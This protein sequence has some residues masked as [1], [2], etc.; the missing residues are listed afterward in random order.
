MAVAT[1]CNLKTSRQSFSTLITRTIP[2]LKSINLSLPDLKRIYCSY[3]P[4]RRD[5]DLFPLTLN[6]YSVYRLWHDHI[7]YQILAKSNNPLLSFSDLKFGV[8][9]TQPI[10]RYRCIS[11]IAQ[12]PRSAD[13]QRTHIPRTSHLVHQLPTSCCWC[14]LPVQAAADV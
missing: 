5:L 1:H 2:S 14:C 8:P 10:S 7:L 13:P 6:A 9:C 11:I 12:P 3:L 4:L